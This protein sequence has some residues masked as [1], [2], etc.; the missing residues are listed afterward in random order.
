[1]VPQ[2][3]QL[4]EQAVAG[5]GLARRLLAFWGPVV[6]TRSLLAPLAAVASVLALA[7]LSGL[8]VGT[9]S[10]LVFLLAAL[11]VLLTDVFGVSVDLALA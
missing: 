11:Y 8:A 2:L 6:D 3:L 10:T 1:M 5:F 7:L 9:L 4:L